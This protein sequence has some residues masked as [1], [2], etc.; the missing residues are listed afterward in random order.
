MSDNDTLVDGEAGN[1]AAKT[2]DE[3]THEENVLVAKK[4]FEEQNIVMMEMRKQQE[5]LMQKLGVNMADLT[6]VEI[7]SPPNKKRKRNEDT[8]SSSQKSGSSLES[9]ERGSLEYD[10]S[11][12]LSND[13]SAKAIDKGEDIN[14]TGRR[15]NLDDD[16]DEMTE[17]ELEDLATGTYK[18]MLDTVEEE[19][20]E[21][22]NDA[23]ANACK[24][25]FGQV[26][27]DAK[28]KEELLKSIKIPRN[29]KMMK[30]PKMNTEMYIRL[31]NIGKD[32]DE[33][34]VNRQ[35]E[36]TKAMVPLLRAL[37]KV[38]EAKDL[39]KKNAK[40]DKNAHPLTQYEKDAY[41]KL[42]DVAELGQ[43][44]YNVLNYFL[45]D[46]TRKRR[47]TVCHGLGSTFGSFPGIKQ[48]PTEETEFLFNEDIMKKMKSDLK[49]LPV[50]AP[51]HSKNW[52]GSGK[53]TRSFQSGN[54]YNRYDNN[55]NRNNGNN[56]YNNYNS[57][58]NN[59]NQN[60]NRNNNFRNNNNNQFNRGGKRRGRR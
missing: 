12:E 57:N 5:L 29:M 15:D 30:P 50:Q 39:M 8:P 37:G 26:I 19:L 18:S 49:K 3:I 32:K 60:N 9:Q 40:R 54:N 42:N 58:R 31:N 45:T 4:F 25:T 7:Q 35:T 16:N 22:I 44:C 6:Q 13:D 48:T 28:V 23:L 52:R 36:V 51:R 2:P 41:E 20:G 10:I 34:A 53:S 43:K 14:L 27:L 33:A 11:D 21:P 1:G 56:N 38:T 17:E 59:N 46:N 24:R 55:P 47:Y